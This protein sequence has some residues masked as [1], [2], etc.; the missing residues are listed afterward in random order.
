MITKI[1][2]SCFIWGMLLSYIVYG[3]EY[4]RITQSVENW[5]VFWLG[6]PLVALVC[7]WRH[8]LVWRRPQRRRRYAGR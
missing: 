3:S 2:V 5:A 7:L 1:I 4:V 8:Y 6:L